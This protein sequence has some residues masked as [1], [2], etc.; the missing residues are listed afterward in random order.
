MLSNTKHSR[1]FQQLSMRVLLFITLTCSQLF[2]AKSK[3]TQ[4]NVIVLVTD[5][6]GY[7]DL[8]RHGHPILKTPNLDSLY[9]QMRL[10]V[11][12]L[13]LFSFVGS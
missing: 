3:D 12:I 8:G 2:A 13:Q 4:P 7:A 1:L 11:L 6:Q 9:D 10:L 5:D